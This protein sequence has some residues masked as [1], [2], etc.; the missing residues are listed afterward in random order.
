V[1]HQSRTSATLL[2][3]LRLDSADPADW[4]AF[5]ER[6]GPL[7][8]QWCRR[9]K[10]QD[11]DALDLTQ[12]VLTRVASRLKTFE[13]D[14]SQSFRAYV[15][16]VTHY[17][18][19]DLLEARKRP[20]AGTGDT[21]TLDLLNTVEAREELDAR[22]ADAFDRELLE[23][24]TARVRLRVEPRTWEAFR[25]TAIEGLSG[26]EAAGRIGMEV[27]TVFKAKSKIQKMLREEI[28]RLE[29]GA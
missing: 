19:C 27:A 4:A 6:Y 18:W 20:G 5:V 9:W 1:P 22:L 26:A 23:E 2:G 16:T 21:V 15:K 12:D 17:A 11:A 29:G 8:R 14:P 7:I 28:T 10:L 3:R 13:Y 25:L 24:A